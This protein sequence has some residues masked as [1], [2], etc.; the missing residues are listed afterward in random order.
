MH[1]PGGQYES[2]RPIPYPPEELQCVL[3]GVGVGEGEE[4]VFLALHNDMYSGDWLVH[5]SKSAWPGDELKA[6]L[7][8]VGC[9]LPANR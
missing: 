7:G 5:Q 8:A 2:N 6:Q 9:D 4:M 1:S 3:L